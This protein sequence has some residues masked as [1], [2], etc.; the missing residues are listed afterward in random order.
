MDEGV[1]RHIFDPFF[2]TKEPGAGTGLGLAVVLG[3]VKNHKG[4]I[5]CTSSP[6]CGTTFHIL[7]PASATAFAPLEEPAAQNEII[8][9]TEKLL[10][11]DDEISI[12]ETVKDTI[13]F[14]GYHVE[15][16]QSGEEAL[17]IYTKQKDEIDLVVLDLIMPGAG[18]KK[19]LHAILEINPEA[20]VLMTSGY[21]SASQAEELS[22]AGAAG[23]IHKPYRPEDLLLNIRRLFD[24]QPV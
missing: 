19:C 12:L 17:K 23:F 18:G 9:G 16:A 3:I 8:H 20:K 1:I 13:M 22:Q 15:T 14:F 21:V 10:V 24:G 11:V 6:G 2:T 4:V 7:L 5:S